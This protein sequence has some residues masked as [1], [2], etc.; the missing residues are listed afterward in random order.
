MACLIVGDSIALGIHSHAPG[1]RALAHKGWSS[2]RWQDHYRTTQLDADRVLISLGSNDGRGDTLA[3]IEAVRAHVKAQQVIWVVPACNARAAA[4][5]LA[6]AR[7][8]G[9][10]VVRIGALSP[11]G[12]HPT[13][14]EYG[15]MARRSGIARAA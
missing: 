13:G 10:G 2:A 1:C 8:Y 9:D 7:R 14:R 11:D 6:L 12:I 15:R 4:A 3:R 5:V